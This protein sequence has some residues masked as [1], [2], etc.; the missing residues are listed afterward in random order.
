MAVDVDVLTDEVLRRLR[1]ADPATVVTVQDDGAIGVRPPGVAD[2]AGADRRRRVL[3][4]FVASQRAP[5]PGE[6]ATRIRNGLRKLGHGPE[7][8][9][10]SG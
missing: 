4:T 2:F 7:R 9:A 3:A 8:Q 1:E 5:R 6:V 10:L